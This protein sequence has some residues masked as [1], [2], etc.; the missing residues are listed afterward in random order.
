MR[1]EICIHKQPCIFILSYNN[2][3]VCW[4]PQ[5][6]KKVDEQPWIENSGCFVYQLLPRKMVRKERDVSA[7]D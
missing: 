1:R 7:A 5:F 2:F 6:K 3:S 4:Q